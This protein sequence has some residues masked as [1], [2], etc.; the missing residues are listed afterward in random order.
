MTS[1]LCNGM[2]ESWTIIPFDEISVNVLIMYKLK[3]LKSARMS[4]GCM[5]AQDKICSDI[6][7]ML[8]RRGQFHNSN[9]FMCKHNHCP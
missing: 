5:S 2:N 9:C 8:I 1:L 6:Y 4:A 3:G 7:Q